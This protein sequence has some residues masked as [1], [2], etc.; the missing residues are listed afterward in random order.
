MRV[1]VSHASPDSLSRPPIDEPLQTGVRA[2]DAMLTCGIGQ[3]SAFSPV[4]ESA[5]AR[6]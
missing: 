6:C 3:R 2:I 1:D 4:L 5:R